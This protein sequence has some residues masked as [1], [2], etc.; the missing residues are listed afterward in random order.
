MNDPD[1]ERV[2]QAKEGDK[3]VF[4]TLV[5]QYYE[6][7]YA[8]VFGV[9]R[10]REA[11]RDVT[12]EVFVKAWRQIQKFAGDSKFK[13]WIYRI[14]V[15]AAIDWTRQRKFTE[16][17]DATDSSGE[18]DRPALVIT[19][20]KAGPRE[21]GTQSELRRLLDHAIEQLSPEHR[22]VLVM[23]EWQELSYDEIAELLGVQIGTVMSRLFYARKKLAEILGPIKEKI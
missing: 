11:A 9:V 5:N 23:R 7:V 17:L 2:R 15:N 3:A 22:A 19:D 10:H 14:A 18:E 6:M 13:T 20:P 21:L 1:F 4:G 8:V 16:S 12:Q